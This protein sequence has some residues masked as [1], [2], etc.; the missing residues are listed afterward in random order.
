MRTDSR[1]IENKK[2][3]GEILQEIREFLSL[4]RRFMRELDLLK[5]TNLP[6]EYIRITMKATAKVADKACL[7]VYGDNNGRLM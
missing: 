6:P 7:Y 4:S 2:E 5:S 1:R 3:V